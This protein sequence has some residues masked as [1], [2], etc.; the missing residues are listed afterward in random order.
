MDKA[1]KVRVL[2]AVSLWTGY[3]Q[4][5]CLL[6]GHAEQWLRWH[7]LG[8]E[9]RHEQALFIVGAMAPKTLHPHFCWLGESFI[10]YEL[11]ANISL[12]DLEHPVQSQTWGKA[13][14]DLALLLHFL[15]AKPV[16]TYATLLSHTNL[17]PLIPTGLCLK[18]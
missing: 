8:P 14:E 18:H 16:V 6:S 2:Q 11:L 4:R 5:F 13:G 9:L 10:N 1:I 7:H 12:Q 17:V 3:K 15:S